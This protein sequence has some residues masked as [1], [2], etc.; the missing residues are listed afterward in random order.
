MRRQAGPWFAAALLLTAASASAAEVSDRDRFRL[1]NDCYSM[2]VGVLPEGTSDI[3]LT[4]E[5]I[6]IAARSKLRAARLYHPDPGT[7]FLFV[8]VHVV[9]AAFHISVEYIKWVED[10]ASGVSGPALTWASPS[11]GVHGHD[12]SFILSAVSQKVDKFIDE[13]LRVNEDA[14]K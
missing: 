6:T 3:G 1:W 10:S 7:P 9:R 14:C 12:A 13:Y 11:T 2:S 8:R 4:K 5:A